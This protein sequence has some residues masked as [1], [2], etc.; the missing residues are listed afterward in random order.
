MTNDNPDSSL[1]GEERG[2]VGSVELVGHHVTVVEVEVEGTL[3]V[4]MAT[5]VGRWVESRP[6]AATVEG[7]HGDMGGVWREGGREGGG[8]GV[9]VRNGERERERADRLLH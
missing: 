9:V 6:V 8:R 2:G 1:R 3:W 4:A 5:G 7:D